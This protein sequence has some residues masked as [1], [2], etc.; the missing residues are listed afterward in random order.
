MRNN[1]AAILNFVF[2]KDWVNHK[3][4]TQRI[5]QRIT[6]QL[7]YADAWSRKFL[8]ILIFET[9]TEV[10]DKFITDPVINWTCHTNKYAI[11]IGYILNML[12]AAKKKRKLSIKVIYFIRRR[13]NKCPGN[14]ELFNTYHCFLLFKQISTTSQQCTRGRRGGGTR[15]AELNT[16]AL[17]WTCL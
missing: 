7:F 11:H 10:M 8:V 1:S 16:N 17:W 14:N 15:A 2:W 4:P 3:T 6:H 9:R 12:A 5:W 13:K